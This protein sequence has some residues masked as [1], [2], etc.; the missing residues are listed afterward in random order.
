MGNIIE[1]KSI[2]HEGINNIDDTEFLEAIKTIL[3]TKYKPLIEYPLVEAQ[4]E[5]IAES[6]EQISRGEYKTNEEVFKSIGKWLNK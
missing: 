4:R 5:R 1:L 3:F 2:I 6:K